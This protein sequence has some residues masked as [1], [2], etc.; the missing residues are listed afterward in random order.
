LENKISP[1]SHE[2]EKG[3]SLSRGRPFL[4]SDPKVSAQKVENTRN[5]VDKVFEE[6]HNAELVVIVLL[7]TIAFSTGFTIPGGFT[8]DVEKGEE[9]KLVQDM[10]VII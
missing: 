9:H 4:Y 2:L 1:R 7:A 8:T 6:R 3:G 5:M 10:L